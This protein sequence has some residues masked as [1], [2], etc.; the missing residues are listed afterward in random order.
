MTETV[1]TPVPPTEGTW[2]L[3]EYRQA[4]AALLTY[5]VNGQLGR[6]TADRIY[7]E[8]VEQRAGAKYSSCGDLAHWL[9][10]RLGVRAP[11]VNRAEFKQ[12]PGHGWRV[13]WNLTYLTA[14]KDSTGR[15]IN[16]AARAMRKQTTL[17]LFDSGDI[18]QVSNVY[19]GHVLCVVGHDKDNPARIFTAE[20]GQPGGAAKEH[21]LTLHAATG[22]VFCGANQI[23][24]AVGLAEALQEPGTVAPDLVTIDRAVRAVYGAK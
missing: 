2:G 9:A 15:V 22:L 18:F 17:P 6:S 7:K 5:A 24:H 1:Q 20:Y 16:P 11:W 3:L 14:D 23:T 19:G 10:Y 8:I 21:L 4:A 13:E 12:P